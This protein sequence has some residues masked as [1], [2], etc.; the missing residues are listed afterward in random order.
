MSPLFQKIARGLFRAVGKQPLP[1]IHLEG[2]LLG[3]TIYGVSSLSRRTTSSSNLLRKNLQMSGIA[4]SPRE[5]RNL[6]FR[7]ITETGKALLETFAI[8]ERG[9]QRAVRWVKHC[10]GWQDVERAKAEGKGI[11]FLTP[12]LGCYEITSLYYA[13]HYPITVLYRPPRKRWLTPLIEAGRSQGRVKLAPTNARGVRDLLH[14]LKQ[15]EAIGILPDQIP[16]R[17]EGEWAPFFG[18]PAYTMT[19]VSRIAEK[20][21]APVIMVYGERLSWGR[22]F[23][24]HFKRLED[25]SVDSVAGLNL[26]V[27]SQIRACPAQYQ[28]NYHRYNIRRGTREQF[29]GNPS[30]NEGTAEDANDSARPD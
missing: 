24:L 26:A 15:G 21:G 3:W 14:A 19:L 29:P 30:P 28:W 7:N 13:S 27:E 9:E 4:G 11:I 18:R 2:V 25:G 8:W 10:E 20:T 5:Y 12:H 1:L 23:N 22:G 16:G 6:L 17:G